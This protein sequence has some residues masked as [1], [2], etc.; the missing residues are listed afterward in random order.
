MYGNN[1]QNTEEELNVV[2]ISIHRLG[3]VQ[4]AGEAL[5]TVRHGQLRQPFAGSGGD[6]RVR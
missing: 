3:K 2:I 4:G 5:V 6:G 1:L